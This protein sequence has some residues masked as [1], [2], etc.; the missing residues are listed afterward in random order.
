[1]DLLNGKKRPSSLFAKVHAQVKFV[2][3]VCTKHKQLYAEVYHP[4]KTL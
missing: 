1:M 4:L 3:D 2:M